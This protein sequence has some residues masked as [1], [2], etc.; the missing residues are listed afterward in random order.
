MDEVK[1]SS[2]PGRTEG[3]RDLREVW[4]EERTEKS[5]GFETMKGLKGRKG[6]KEG[7]EEIGE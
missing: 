3:L 7:N 2:N 6:A 1:Q 5:I 4:E